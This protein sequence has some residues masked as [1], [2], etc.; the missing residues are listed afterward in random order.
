MLQGVNWLPAG[1]RK[2]F[3][4][5]HM[6]H[7]TTGCAVH[8][9]IAFAGTLAHWLPVEWVTKP[10]IMAV[11]RSTPCCH[12]L[13][14]RVS[15]LPWM[16]TPPLPFLPWASSESL[17]CAPSSCHCLHL[18]LSMLSSL[19]HLLH[20]PHLAPKPLFGALLQTPTCWL[21]AQANKPG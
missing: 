2:K 11:S 5:P 20:H 9:D 15:L 13:F 6:Q 16:L 1:V 4:F 21:G 18:P 10:S 8:V 17:P 12:L 14:L 3:L 7:C 19:P